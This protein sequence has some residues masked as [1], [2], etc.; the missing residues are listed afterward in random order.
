MTNETDL[1]DSNFYIDWLETSISNEYFNYYEYSEFTNLNPIGNGA[2]GRV[3]RAYWKNTPFALKIFNNDKLMLKEVVNEIKLQKRVDSHENILRF[4]GITK[5]ETEYSLVLEYADSGT[6]KAYLSNHFNKLDWNDNYQLTLQLASAVEYMHNHNIIHRDLH[7]NNILIH[8]KKIKIADF[9]LSKKIVELSN[10]SKI[11]ESSITSKIFGVIPYVDP[12]S[13]NNQ[14][15]FCNKCENYKLNK[16]SDVYSVGVLMWQISSGRRPFYAFYAEGVE[17]DTSLALAIQ[18]GKR[19]KII[20]GTPVEYSDLYTECWKYEPNE[21][22][23]MQ[24]VVSI[25]SYLWNNRNGSI[26]TL[27]SP[28]HY[29]IIND[30]NI[31]ERTDNLL[32]ES[33]SLDINDDLDLDN[34]VSIISR[35]S[36]SLQNQTFIK[37]DIMDPE[38]N[39][40]YI[41]I[42]TNLSNDS[43]NSTFN[44]ISKI[45]IDK[46][47]TVIIKN[48]DKGK[49]F[50]QI[51]Q[52]IEQKIF[53]LN[54]NTN[55]LVNWIIENQDK[56]KYIWF[57][58]L[59]YYYNIGVEENDNRAF[60]LFSK[61]A[62]NN[63]SIAQV[64]LAKCYYDGYGINCNRNLTFYWYQKSVENGSI[65]GQFYL[66]HCCE[67]GIGIVK[68]EKES[69]Y[70]YREATKNGVE[71]DE[72]KAF[73]YYVSLAKQGIADAQYQLGNCFYYGIGIEINKIQAKCWY[74]KAT[75]GGNI[76]AKNILKKCYNI[77]KV[78]VEENK[79]IKF[80]KI[81]FLRNLSQLGLNYVGKILLKTNY[82]KSFYYFQKAAVN[83]CKFAL[84][85]LGE[86][87]QLGKGVKKDYRKAFELYNKSAK[88]G[89]INAQFQLIYCYNFGFGIEINKVKAFELVSV[90]AKT[91]DNDALYLLGIHYAFGIGI[92]ENEQKAFELYKKLAKNE[93]QKL[94]YLPSNKEIEINKEKDIYSKI[95][96]DN[97]Y[98]NVKLILGYCY[99]NGIGTEINKEKAL[100]I[101]KELAKNGNVIAQ[102]L[103]GIIYSNN[104][105]TKAFEYFKKLA[106]QGDLNA[107]L[108]LGHC[109]SRGIG[110]EIDEAK[111]F[112][113]YKILAE[114][115][116]I[117]AQNYLGY[118]YEWGKGTEENLEKA[119]YWYNKGA[120]GG[121]EGAQYNLGNCYKNGKGVEKD[122][123]KAFEYYK[124]SADQ[125]YL[126][127][128]LQLGYCYYKRKGVEKDEIKAFKY[129]KKSADH[130]DL[131]AQFQ[132]GYFYDEGIGT[133]VDKTKAFE[134][135]TITAEKGHKIAQNNLGFLY[136]KGEG[137][138]KNLEKAIYWYNKAA[139]KGDKVAQYNLGRC[140]ENVKGV[141]KDGNK[142][143]EYYKKSADQ[144]YL[145]AQCQL[146]YC[147][148]KGIGTEV[149]KT[150]AFEL[151]TIAA[152]KGHKIAQNNLGF[153]YVKG[154]GTEKNLEKAIYWYNKAAEYGCK[155][156]QYNLGNCYINGIGV[157]KDENKAFE[158]YK[159]SADQ[160]YLNA[161][162][163]LG[164]CYDKR[165]GTETD[166]AKAIEMYK[167]AAEKGNSMAQ[168]NL[169]FL[170]VKGEGTVKDSEKAVYWFQK[171]IENDNKFASDNLGICYELGIG[172]NKDKIKAFELYKKSAEKGYLNA[173]FHLGYCY[174]NGIGTK[175]D[176]EKG[177]GLYNKAAKKENEEKILN[178]LNEVNYWYQK[179]AE[180]DNKVALYKLGEIYE[181]GKGVYKNEIRAFDYYQQ[182]AEKGCIN[183]KYKVGN[184][185]LHGIIV[186]IDKRKA[187][188]LYKEAAEGGNCDAKNCLTLLYKQGEVLDDNE[189]LVSL[190]M[191][192]ESLLK[193][194]VSIDDKN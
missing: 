169:G 110:T 6:L 175:I 45:I 55:N 57:Y 148:D 184:Y 116:H 11:A 126:D 177:I 9:G 130:G 8:Q 108:G 167:I 5:A 163:K 86:C 59:L 25:L 23:D 34:I 157:E 80:Y 17:Y 43:L 150:K 134:L 178:D 188:D 115:E 85:N 82:E 123:R 47:I 46:L 4:Y 187:L 64:Y 62:D 107:Q 14:Y 44:N 48:H 26:N 191:S 161:Q 96:A 171:A 50:Y 136:V 88:Q 140:Y 156:A 19:E 15:N 38:D 153:L 117:H 159:K 143:F 71:K 97:K 78:K 60:E 73:K 165:I 118:S 127:A 193:Q 146:G 16:K 12:K 164:Y 1:K 172:I 168:N 139:E 91:G 29:H 87:Y 131:E 65:A 155:S 41:S 81:L 63:Y 98:I 56:S 20:D 37:S 2:Y 149:D 160:G 176:K 94:K 42:H 18:G 77:K 133:E 93:N 173:K 89:Y 194:E 90:M 125:G 121:C 39:S 185:F 54:Q 58:G 129:Y 70:W 190:V 40:S 49:T 27:I 74:E 99:M 100:K 145:N 10:T 76:I 181:L 152:E 3:V 120:E 109:Y 180:Y 170:Y 72:I 147:Y 35:E 21:R 137:T 158:Y 22:P 66:G 174:I 92:K 79:K 122:E 13:F 138:E 52:F 111:A 113:L 84:F 31:E 179:S 182:A 32:Q 192:F 30:D 119:I 142:A 102:Y 124:I 135:Y 166:K 83:G 36:S 151:Y 53:R 69:V 104:N 132:L 141:E 105:E 186:D 67:F 61:A 68:N 103:L 75:N 95:L 114:K 51:Q 162:F 7:A 33:E 106:D 24:E 28:M 144:G 101:F 154:K 183:G 189:S 112:E 128:Q